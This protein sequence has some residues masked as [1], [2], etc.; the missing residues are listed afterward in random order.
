MAQ[1]R[2]SRQLRDSQLRLSS[3]IGNDDLEM[4]AAAELR[5]P[6]PYYRGSANSEDT[7][8]ATATPPI[9][10]PTPTEEVIAEDDP[11]SSLI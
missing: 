9:D 10:I 1:Q 2:S 3:S 7:I 5:T 11:G 4:K 8:R 6:R